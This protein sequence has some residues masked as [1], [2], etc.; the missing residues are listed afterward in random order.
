MALALFDLDHTLLEGD[1]DQLWGD[2]L[3]HQELVDAQFY[4]QQKNQYY[5]DYLDGCLDMQAFL[6]FCASAL[7]QFSPDMLTTLGNEFA[8]E[9]LEPRLRQKGIE[10]L[11]YHRHQG[12]TLLVITATN[13][14]LASQATELISVEHLIASDLEVIEDRYTGKALGTPSYREG[15]IKRLETWLSMHPFDLSETTFYSDSHNDL[16]LLNKV[17]RPIA[18]NP[19]ELLMQHALE[20]HW[21]VLDWSQP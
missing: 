11:N 15:K 9:W 17:G 7:T 5:Q 6:S 19:D 14:F 18:V 1:C 21:T 12:D 3:A 2:F 10:A 16:P 13:R 8:N 20:H 4:Q